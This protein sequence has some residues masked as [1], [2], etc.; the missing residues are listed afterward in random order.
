[1]V[2]RVYIC[3]NLKSPFVA[4]QH[5]QLEGCNRNY[6]VMLRSP[7]FVIK[8]QVKFQE[9]EQCWL[10]PRTYPP[11]KLKSG[12]VCCQEEEDDEDMTPS[13]TIIDYKVSSF[14][15]LRSIFWY[16]SLGST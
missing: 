7:C 4:Q 8:K 15:Y 16:N 1:M 3:S 9:E 13:D 6:L 2:H 14:L 11:T 10:L 5:D 12:M